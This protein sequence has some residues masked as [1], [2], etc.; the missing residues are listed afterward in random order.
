LVGG[1]GGGIHKKVLKVLGGY[2][3]S[4]PMSAKLQPKYPIIQIIFKLFSSLKKYNRIILWPV[5]S[6]HT[7]CLLCRQSY[8]RKLKVKNDI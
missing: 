6:L 4:P 1:G 2:Y 8:K 5:F 3:L 7:F